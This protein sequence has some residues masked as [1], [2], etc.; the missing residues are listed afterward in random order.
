M[1]LDG[2]LHLLQIQTSDLRQ[3]LRRAIQVLRVLS[4]D[5]D[6]E[7]VTILDEDLAVFLET[8]DVRR[9]NP[10][11]RTAGRLQC[12]FAGDRGGVGRTQPNTG[13]L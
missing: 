6:G 9:R 7:R 11:Q 4:E 13:R 5:R 2:L 10:G 3:Q 8:D 1:P 12:E